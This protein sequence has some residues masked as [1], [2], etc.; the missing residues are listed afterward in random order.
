MSSTIPLIDLDAWFDGSD[1]TRSALAA[2]VD[3]HL[4]RCGFL[5]VI[6]HR[7]D[8][9][10][11]ADLRRTARVFFHLPETVKGQTMPEEGGLYRGW[12]GAGR[13]SNAATYGVDTPPDLKETF[14]FGTV[15]ALPDTI[16][17]E[18][19]MLYAS[20]LWPEE[21]ATFQTL[22]ERWWRAN[23]ELA[24]ELLRLFALALRLEADEIV[25]HCRATTST[26]NVN[27]YWP[28][29]HL[30]PESGQYRIGPHTDFGTITILD[31]EPGV[32]GLQIKDEHGEW[33]DA[34]IVD[35]GLIV[36]TGDMLRQWTN[37]RW[38]SNEHRVLPPAE[39]APDEELISLIFFHEPDAAAVIEP[40]LTCVSD[41]DPPRYTPI[42]S[43]DYLAEKFAAL[44][45]D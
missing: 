2:E 1:E 30:P 21:P 27:W 26:G 8:A 6:N 44:E 18:S 28:R 7:I 11:L 24:D 19:P 20:N 22:A 23:R 43:R 5:V 41:V 36:N 15:D 16:R 37:D 33:I 12:I 42:T 14:A 35:G 39:R 17:A 10:L 25:A 31:R 9:A 4:Q 34:P 40:F 32:G 13:E 38:Q 45:V 3:A 29:T